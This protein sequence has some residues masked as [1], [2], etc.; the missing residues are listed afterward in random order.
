[1]E[2]LEQIDD[3]DIEEMDINWQ[4]AMI[5]IR[6]KKFYKKTGRR[7]R[8]DGNKP[9]GF[10]KK[11]LECFKCHN[12]GHFAREC[13]S[14][15]TNDGKK[16][17]SFYQDQGAG[18]KE[19]NQNCLL[20]MDDGVVNWGEH[21]EE[22]VETNH[23]LMAISSNNE[24][25]VIST[26][27]S[28]RTD[29]IFDSGISGHNDCTSYK[30]P[31]QH[32]MYS[33]DMK[34]PAL[35][36]DYA[37][38]IAKATSDESKLW[39][40]RLGT[41]E[42]TNSVGTLQTPNANAFE[43]EDEVEELIVVP[44][45]VKHTA[46][47]V[48]P[49]KSSTNS[50]AEEFLIE[51]QNLKTQE[52]VL[53]YGIQKITHE[54]CSFYEVE[55]PL[56]GLGLRDCQLGKVSN[57][58][59]RWEMVGVSCR[60]DLGKVEEELNQGVSGETYIS[61]Q[62]L[63]AAETLAEVPSQIKTKRRNVKT[64]VRRRLDAEDVSIGFEGFEDVSTGFTDIK[65][66]S[67]KV[68]SS[69]KH[70]SASQREGKAVLEETPQTKRTKKQ[71][72]EEH[73]REDVSEVDYAQRMVGLISLRRKL[74][75]EQKAKAQ[76]DKPMTQAQQRQYMATYL[77]NQGGWKLAQI[78]KLTDE[79]LKEKFEYLMRSMEREDVSIP[80]D[81]DKESVKREEE[82]DIKKPVLRY[83]KRKSLAR[84]GLQKKPEFAKSGTKEDVE[85]YMEE[86][87][88]EPS[89]KEFPMSLLN[90]LTRDDL[91]ELYRLMMLKYGDNRPEEEFERV[92]WGDLKTMFDP[93]SEEDA[94][95]K[96][97]HQQ[98]I[99][100]WRYFHSCSVHCLTVEAAHIYMLTEVKYPLPP[101]VCK[102]M[103]EKKLLGDRKDEV[104]QPSDPIESVAD[105]AVHK[106]LGDSLVRAATTA[107][108]LEAEQDSGNINKT[109][110]K[111][112]PNESSSQG[113]NSGGG[114]RVL[115]LEKTKTSQHNKIASLKRR[116]KMLEKKNS[117]RTHRLKILYK[118]GLT[119]RVESSDNEESLCEDA[120]KDGRIDAIDADEKIILVSAAGDIVSAASAATTVSVATTTTATINTVDDIT[121]A[122]ALKEMKSTKPKKKGIDKGKGILIEPIKKKDQILLDE[123]TALNLQAE[124]DE[125]E[126]LARE[127]AKK[128]KEVNIALVETWD[129]IQA[130]I[131]VDHQLAER[132]Q[133]QEQEEL[134]IKEKAT[135]FQQL[136]EKRRNHFVAKRAEEKRNNPPT[137]A[138]QRKIMCTYLKNMKGYK[139]NDLKLKEFDSIQEM[140][141]RAFKRVNT[142]EDFRTEFVEGKEKRAETKLVQE[143]TKNQKVEDDKEIT[144]L[145]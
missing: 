88:D 128:E 55:L 92:L 86:R 35:T 115:D 53:L 30:V 29:G 68:S 95:W 66:T 64:G 127:K 143:S 85:A 17:D 107:S 12:T 73:T 145:K 48:G 126:R 83:T 63:E 97:P 70:V 120:S 133:A 41:S 113:T 119:A 96:L 118:V 58:S 43:E 10:D 54:I 139:L 98:Q 16:R 78:K 5:A 23:A 62:G 26:Q 40:R 90:D 37:C 112:T 13:P 9:V 49:R 3:M 140:F 4:I 79:E 137:K 15:G 117:S 122:Q 46:S 124:F 104:P 14:K 1:M 72:R 22:E 109:Q 18:K 114:P 103:L 39:H 144:E 131:D 36:K 27:D 65:S 135:L 100:N 89:S 123:E 6:M 2:D 34:T 121:L 142:F 45:A 110:S 42:V 31:R 56:G 116:V 32:N 111:A 93:P 28:W 82:F 71:N 94:I 80:K 108:S 59:G 51:L 134:S 21:T 75:A 102:A 67:E 74:I 11:K 76:R 106:E 91:K 141:D 84:K 33:F 99:L 19:Q 20:T 47:K 61:P 132:M 87:V 50:K 136:L 25:R 60:G 129:D 138:Q 24:D 77:K 8:I 130:K 7:V 69:G 52:K 105:E 81:K 57:T 44:P 125:E 38:L 101:R